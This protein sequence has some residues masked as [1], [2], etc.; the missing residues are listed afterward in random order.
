MHSQDF[1]VS[2]LQL[3][4]DI[5]HWDLVTRFMHFRKE[6][7][8]DQKSW[9]LHHADGVE[10]EQYDGFD[11][12]YVV[13]HRGREVLG[14]ARLKRTDRLYG[15]GKVVYSYMIRDACLGLLP[16]MPRELCFDEPPV[17]DTIW[18]LTRFAARCEPGVGEAI[19]RASN[20]FL[21]R[22]D[23]TRCLFLGPP[24]FLRMAKKLGWDPQAMGGVCQNDDGRFLAFQCGVIDPH[25]GHVGPMLAAESAALA[26]H[27]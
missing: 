5:S 17:D 7:F 9:P 27:C 21:F 4:H 23:A 19:L 14:G 25:L 16:G 1:D 10:F 13:A 22:Q 3:P 18:E 24:A 15:Q 6:V 8:V 11:T 12:V 26:G 20:D 2:V